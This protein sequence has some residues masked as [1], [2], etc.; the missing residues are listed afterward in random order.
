MT[1]RTTMTGSW[2]RPPK[3]L[4]L[5][6][7][8]PTGEL[9]PDHANEYLE[10]ER[11]AIRDQL[12]PAGAKSRGLDAV[13]NGGQ[14]IAGYTNYLPARFEGFSATERAAMQMPPATIQEFIDSN[15]ALAA[16][17]QQMSTVFSLPKIA[18]PL[19][20]IGADKA[21]REAADLRRLGQEEGAPA[22]FLP[23]PSPGVITIFYPN[24]PEV[25]PTHAEYV[26]ALGRELRKEYE[27]ILG[28]PDV[29]LQIDA[30]DLAM[31]KQTSFEW[32]GDFEKVL[33]LHVDAI[34]EA[35]RGLPKD[36]IRVHYCYGNYAASHMLDADFAIVVPEI[37]RLKV[38]AIVGE[39]ANPHHEGDLL[40]LKQYVKEHGWPNHLGFVGG[41]IDV[42]TPIVETPRT[43]QFR[44]DQLA[45]AVGAENTWGGTDCGFETFAGV[46]G[47]TRS[48]ALQKLSALA[49]GAAL[50]G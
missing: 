37:A 4:E 5:L 41:V 27:A 48:V 19:R 2:H 28:V 32:G 39:L 47:V 22:V 8:S 49:E 16:M 31:G 9:S 38:S 50:S 43:V 13:S 11:S 12:H 29:V 1:Y 44:L 14:R 3:I 25:Y 18:A 45:A 15:P 42:K 23:A 36:R 40:V 24:N 35:I 20:Y 30:P 17:L 34:N 7:K 46:N 10:A 6:Q 21:A 26:R 33:P